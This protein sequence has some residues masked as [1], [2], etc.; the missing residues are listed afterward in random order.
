[1]ALQAVCWAGLPG[2]AGKQQGEDDVQIIGPLRNVSFPLFI[3]LSLFF[4]YH[5]SNQKHEFLIYS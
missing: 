1:M 5:G 2:S 3:L 4:R